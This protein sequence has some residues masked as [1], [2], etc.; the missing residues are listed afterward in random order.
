MFGLHSQAENAPARFRADW[1]SSPR[2]RAL[3]RCFGE[4]L[5][6]PDGSGQADVAI[7][8]VF[9]RLGRNISPGSV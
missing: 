2:H 4:Q 9:R 5:Y 6:Q 1:T 8:F 7:M 3:A